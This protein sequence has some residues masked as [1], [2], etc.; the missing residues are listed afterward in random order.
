VR[1][2]PA[3]RLTWFTEPSELVYEIAPHRESRVGWYRCEA[4]AG[5]HTLH[6]DVDAESV[7][8]W[9][10]GAET[11]VR[12]GQVRLDAPL[13][14]VSQ[15]AL[16]VEQKP[17]VYAGAAIRQPVR[18]ECAEAS[19]PLGDWSQYALE[20]YSGGAV[21]KKSFTLSPKQLQ[22]EVV[23]DLGAV[24]T[25]AEVA[26]N[27]HVVGV[28]LARPYRFD[29]TRQVHEGDN[30]LQVTVYNTLAN[31]FSTGPYE[32]DYV[33]PGQTVSG[34]LGPVTVSFPARVTL[35]ARPVWNTSL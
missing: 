4:P 34:L 27:G 22:G 10:N 8:V 2:R 18:F 24:N 26:V 20:S 1:D 17:G 19:L 33:F 14:D 12:D 9:V 13:T 35:T 15:I 32:S 16:R 3:A 29:I 6:L 31:Y 30:E 11:A 23:L 7:Q 25:T 21:Y 5:L 28:R